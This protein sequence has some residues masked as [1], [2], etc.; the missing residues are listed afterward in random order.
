MAGKRKKRKLGSYPSFSVIGSMLLALFVIG[1]FGIFLVLTNSLKETIRQNMQAQIYLE[2]DISESQRI[3]IEQTLTSGDFIL[4][5]E[6]KPV[7]QFISRED[8]AKKFIEETGEDFYEFLGDN[9]LR[10]SYIIN[11]AMEQQFPDKLTEMKSSVESIPGVFEMDY[12]ES[13]LNRLIENTTTISLILVGFA[14]VLMI[15]VIL[16]INNTIKL[17]LFSQ[18]FLIRSMQLVGAKPSFIQKPFLLRSVFHG[19]MAASLAALALFG[20]LS[21]GFNE[22][23][24]LKGISDMNSI[25]LVF[26]VLIV[27]GSLVGFSGTFI[28]IRRYMKL[29]LDEL[30]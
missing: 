19:F 1:L 28:A 2:K 30:Y 16:L 10:D 4:K 8:A 5:K 6:G 22:F 27:L 13:L 3:Q 17:A 14:S 7:M 21:Y 23:P 25:L 9:P 29:S 18:R 12:V 11:I 20:L 15:A 26:A 24:D